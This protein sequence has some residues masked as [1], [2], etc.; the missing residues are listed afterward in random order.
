LPAREERESW[1]LPR[2][3]S[4]LIED[5][6]RLF[7]RDENHIEDKPARVRE[8]QRSRRFEK[9]LVGRF[10]ESDDDASSDPPSEVIGKGF[11]SHFH[12]DFWEEEGDHVKET[13]ASRSTN[14]KLSELQRVN[15]NLD[16]HSPSAH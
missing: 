5:F 1:F 2:E 13:F 3:E 6:D 4:L 7:N 15:D 16:L 8:V 10:A 11:D 12:H 9:Q 14:T